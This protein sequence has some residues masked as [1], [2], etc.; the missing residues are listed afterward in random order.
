MKEEE[1]FYVSVWKE[2][3]HTDKDEE[4]SAEAY[5]SFC[6]HR[7]RR[8]GD[9]FIFAFARVKGQQSDGRN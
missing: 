2:L 9:T 8:R 5:S 7:S 3:K 6:L 1:S 4:E